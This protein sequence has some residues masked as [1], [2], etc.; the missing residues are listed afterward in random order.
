M[1]AST[2]TSSTVNKMARLLTTPS[3]I[4]RALDWQKVSGSVLSVHIGDSSIDLAVTSHPSTGHPVQALSS[5][6]MELETRK[7]RKVLK[8]SVLSELSNIVEDWNV[9]GLVV[10]WP[11]QKEGWCG[12]PCGNVLH[13]LDQIAQDTNIVNMKRQV[14]LWDGHHFL[15]EEDEWGRTAIYST[16]SDQEVHVASKEQYREEGMLAA[17]IAADYLRHHFPDLAYDIEVR[18]ASAIETEG[19]M[20]SDNDMQSAM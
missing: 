6:P 16:T 8:K 7:N 14:A 1:S 13:T 10:S 5:I 3:K 2:K 17:D 19:R 11:V 12:K 15:N 20:H 4:A 9:C 18:P